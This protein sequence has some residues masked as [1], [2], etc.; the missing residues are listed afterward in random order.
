MKPPIVFPQSFKLIQTQCSVC[1]D[2][3]L[4]L[5]EY[6]TSSQI[7][8]N[9]TDKNSLSRNHPLFILLPLPHTAFPSFRAWKYHPA[10]TSGMNDERSAIIFLRLAALARCLMQV[11]SQIFYSRNKNRLH[12]TAGF[13][14]FQRRAH[15]VSHMCNDARSSVAFLRSKTEVHQLPNHGIGIAHRHRCNQPILKCNEQIATTFITFREA[16]SGT[17]DPGKFSQ[18]SKLATPSSGNSSARM[19]FANFFNGRFAEIKIA[20]LRRKQRASESDDEVV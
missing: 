3:I 17:V 18:R 20:R 14:G 8:I 16:S 12:V 15:T 9:N 10:K 4:L 13:Q 11:P 7:L 5:L 19:G 2:I 1:H 6:V